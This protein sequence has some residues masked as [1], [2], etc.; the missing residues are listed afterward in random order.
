MFDLDQINRL[1]DGTY[2]P[3]FVGRLRDSVAQAAGFRLPFVYLSKASCLKILNKHKDITRMDL[4]RLPLIVAAGD[5]FMDRSEK[6]VD[7]IV[8][9]YDDPE[10]ANGYMA[11]LKPAVTSPDFEI[12]VTAYYRLKPRKY[13]RLCKS[14]K[15]LR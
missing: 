3:L 10:N 1:I 7:C 5:L 13:E 4:L 15:R 8:A 14:A 9:C 12:W 2:D 6:G 11:S